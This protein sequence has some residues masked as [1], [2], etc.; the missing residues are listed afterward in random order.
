MMAAAGC[1]A[2]QLEKYGDVAT[3]WDEDHPHPG[4]PANWEDFEGQEHLG[5]YK[6]SIPS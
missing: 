3:K 2:V 6:R 4:F 1:S 5:N